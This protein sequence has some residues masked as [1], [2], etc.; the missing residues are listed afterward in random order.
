[1]KNNWIQS[2]SEYR[3]REVSQQT[4]QL[5][6]GI[7]KLEEDRYGLFLT[8]ISEQFIL[9]EKVYDVQRSFIDRVK[10]S[11]ANTSGNMGILLNGTRG[12][13]KTI[14][15]EMICNESQMPVIIIPRE[16]EGFTN[17]LAEMT[18]DT[19]I[20]IDEYDKIFSR[21]SSTMLTIMDGVLK[22]DKRLMF[23]LT[24]NN[25]YLNENMYQRPSRIRYI[26]TFGNLSA[27]V[28]KEIVDDRLIHKQWR[29]QTIEFIATLQII[30][31]DLVMSTIQEVN[32]HNEDPANFRDVFNVTDNNSVNYNVYEVNPDTREQKL[33]HSHAQL[34]HHIPFVASDVDESIYFDHVYFGNI[35]EI[36]DTDV[37]K[38]RVKGEEHDDFLSH[39]LSERKKDGSL[40]VPSE[41]VV[42]K[43]VII[44]VE[45]SYARHYS[46]N[47]NAL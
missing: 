10:T 9:P 7:Y 37:I 14:T 17:L 11:W 15:A 24:T 19:V 29:E 45:P 26:K 12:T 1:M 41:K 44:R 22:T 43:E 47:K 38:V 5:P 20:F 28:V 31:I 6:V 46:F 35:Q 42:I 39:M 13:G 4:E 2:N 36:L 30:T 32:I 40:S 3:I 34:N 27:E 33:I 18:Q 21:E 25:S 23:L 8:Q 16:Y